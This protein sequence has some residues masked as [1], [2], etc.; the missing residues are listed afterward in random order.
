M[1]KFYNQ[2]PSVYPSASRDFQ[3]ICRL[4]DIVLNS[5]KHN[6]DGLYSLPNTSADARLT[7]LLAMTLGFKVKRNYDHKQLVA[8]VAALPRILRYKG[9]ATA[10]EMAG[11][12]LIAASGSN[13]AILSEVEDSELLVTIP[14]T[15]VDISLFTDL[16]PY[17]LP[18][19]M[20]CHIRRTD[21]NYYKDAVE[22]GYRDKVIASI[23]PDFY[24]DSDSQSITGLAA[25]Y[26]IPGAASDTTFANYKDGDSTKLNVGLLSNSV[27]PAVDGPVRYRDTAGYSTE[28]NEYGE[29]VIIEN[30]KTAD[31]D[32]G[33]TVEVGE[34][35]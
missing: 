25:M 20:T 13:G 11:R 30:S 21:T 6:V 15:L 19:G 10:V 2:V 14:K 22:L 8:L 26:S 5:V 33:K 1:I 3:Y 16:L 29:T 31:N 7:E 9:T 24:W 17:I 34:E 35:E 23:V 32:A 27:I 18:A 4:I 12:A 28:P